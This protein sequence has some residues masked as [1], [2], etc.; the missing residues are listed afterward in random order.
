MSSP[1]RPS[2]NSL[3]VVVLC[4]QWCGTCRDYAAPF[5]ALGAEFANVAFRWVDIEDQAELVDP[6]EVDNFPSILMSRDGQA[7]FFGSITP[8][9]ETLRRLISAQLND[10]GAAGLPDAEVQALARRIQSLD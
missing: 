9:P 7:V 1:P 4:A 8:H 5:A 6:V 10:T 2:S 3:Q